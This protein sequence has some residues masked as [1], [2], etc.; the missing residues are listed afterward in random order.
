MRKKYCW[1]KKKLASMIAGRRKSHSVNLWPNF[2]FFACP[3]M[4]TRERE[5]QL[6][7]LL[8]WEKKGKKKRCMEKKRAGNFLSHFLSLSHTKHFSSL[9]QGR[10]FLFCDDG[11]PQ[12]VYLQS[13]VASKL[14]FCQEIW[15]SLSLPIF[16]RSFMVRWKKREEEEE[17]RSLFFLPGERLYLSVFFSPQKIFSS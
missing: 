15:L 6:S 3:Q 13:S 9:R 2:F 17:T 4:W 5:T 12:K 8:S 10:F 14:L 11:W 1:R 16:P 7:F